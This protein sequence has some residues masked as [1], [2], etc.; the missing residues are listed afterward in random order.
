MEKEC[1]LKKPFYPKDKTAF[2]RTNITK[3]RFI[4]NGSQI[5]QDLRPF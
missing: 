5:L 1:L 3:I 4:E 2:Q